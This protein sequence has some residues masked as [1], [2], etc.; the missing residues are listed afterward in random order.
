M[1]YHIK[2]WFYTYFISFAQIGS[3]QTSVYFISNGYTNLGGLF[4]LIVAL[5]W[6]CNRDNDYSKL[7]SGIVA[8]MLGSVTG[9]Q[10][11]QFLDYLWNSPLKNS[12]MV[13]VH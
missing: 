13:I 9:A 12:L 4:Q 1:K 8:Y 5:T 7:R 10:W 11:V 2:G 6:L 3:V